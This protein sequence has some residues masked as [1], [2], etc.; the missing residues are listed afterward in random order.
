[1]S[2]HATVR[3]QPV[4]YVAPEAFDAVDMVA[5]D[6]L[7]LLL[8]DYHVLTAQLQRGIG[9]SFIRIVLRAFARMRIDLPHR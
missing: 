5:T 4:F 6:R 3:I 7:A 8:A 2:G 9:L 1:M